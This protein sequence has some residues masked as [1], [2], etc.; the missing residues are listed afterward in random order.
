LVLVFFLGGNIVLAQDTLKIQYA[1]NVSGTFKEGRLNQV[2]IP[3]TGTYKMMAP[4]WE[5]QLSANYKYQKTNGNVVENEF[6]S[7]LFIS[8]FHKKKWFPVIGYFFN[9][10]EFYQLKTRNVGG[11]GFG[12]RIME[13]PHNSLYYYGWVAYDD[14]EFKNISGYR[15]F[16]YNSF[17]T[18]RHELTKDKLSVQYSLYYFQSL[19]KGNNYIWRIEPRLLFHLSKKFSVSINLESHFENI[20]DPTNTKRNSALT[21]GFQFHN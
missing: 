18:G 8:F 21:V 6:L 16:R 15:T 7:R 10:S 4:K 3:I 12:R 20:V 5:M 2:K 19:E 14:T 9:T 17:I 11:G 1:L 13:N